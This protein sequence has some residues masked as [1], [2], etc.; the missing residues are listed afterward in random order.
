MGGTECRSIP[1]LPFFT[2]IS[3]PPDQKN[4]GGVGKKAFAR[5][6][7]IPVH[8][9]AYQLLVLN[10]LEVLLDRNRLLRFLFEHIRHFQPNKSERFR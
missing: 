5:N 9:E 10:V 6:P 1:N 3:R 2:T 7:K 4:S 8:T